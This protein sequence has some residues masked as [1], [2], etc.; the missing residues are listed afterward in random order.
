MSNIQMHYKPELFDIV[1]EDFTAV[2]PAGRDTGN[3]NEK[4]MI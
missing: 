1:V 3:R 2:V 4:K